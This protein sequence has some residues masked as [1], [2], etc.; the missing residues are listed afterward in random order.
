MSHNIEENESKF[1]II[2]YTTDYIKSNEIVANGVA[3]KVV[4]N[5]IKTMEVL[6]TSNPKDLHSFTAYNG[7][8]IDYQRCDD[9]HL[10]CPECSH[11]ESLKKS[12]FK[13]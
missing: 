3:N 9:L 6:C 10:V 2:S 7:R 12:T 8:E 4:H 5:G 13:N 1:V 11:S